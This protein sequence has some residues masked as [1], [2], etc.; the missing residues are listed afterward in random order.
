MDQDD[1]I[2][3]V[4]LQGQPVSLHG[5]NWANLVAKSAPVLLYEVMGRFDGLDNDY[6][7]MDVIEVNPGRHAA[8]R[9]ATRHSIR[10]RRYARYMRR[11]RQGERR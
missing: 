4:I 1:R 11:I 5:R 3:Y 10:A 7:A 6:E 9:D 2:Q 8:R